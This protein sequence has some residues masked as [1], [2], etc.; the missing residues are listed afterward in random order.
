MHLKC[1]WNI[2]ALIVQAF[3]DV[4]RFYFRTPF[5]F[6]PRKP[7]LKWNHWILMT[8]RLLSNIPIRRKNWQGIWAQ[9]NGLVT[10]LFLIFGGGHYYESIRLLVR[11][12]SECIL[13]FYKK[14]VKHIISY[15]Q[16]QGMMF[17]MWISDMTYYWLFKCHI[18][19]YMSH[20]FIHIH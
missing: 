16:T 8:R 2:S 12:C 3:I 18:Q 4:I 14:T 17:V 19:H 1:T 15:Q 10:R 11:F 20:L 13:E 6:I 7:I 9:Q 5:T